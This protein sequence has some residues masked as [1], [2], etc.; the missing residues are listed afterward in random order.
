MQRWPLARKAAEAVLPVRTDINLAPAQG[1]CGNLRR[2]QV[3]GR[4]RLQNRAS[5]WC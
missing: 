5:E 1:C 4:L 3:I 2:G